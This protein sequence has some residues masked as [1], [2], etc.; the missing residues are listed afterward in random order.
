MKEKK[1]LI[2]NFYWFSINVKK[3]VLLIILNEL[4]VRIFRCDIIKCKFSNIF[5]VYSRIYFWCWVF[6]KIDEGV[7]IMWGCEIF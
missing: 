5:Y 2:Y 3:K 7:F 1:R 6:V 4:K